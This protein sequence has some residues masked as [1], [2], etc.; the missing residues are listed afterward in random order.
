MLLSID[1]TV[2]DASSATV[3]T[4]RTGTVGIGDNTATSVIVRT[5]VVITAGIVGLAAIDN[6]AATAMVVPINTTCLGF[7]KSSDRKTKGRDF[8]S[9]CDSDGC[10]FHDHFS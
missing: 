4:A 5:V 2:A 10:G 7:R 1:G 3:V 8:F 6:D 9:D